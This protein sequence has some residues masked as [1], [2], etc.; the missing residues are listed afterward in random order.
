L[1]EIPRDW[2]LA[3]VVPIYKNGDVQQRENYRPVSLTSTVCKTLERLILD[4]LLKYIDERCPISDNQFGFRS[5]RSCSSQ[6]IS[7]VDMIS[8][9][10]DNN[11]CVDVI[12]LDQSKAFDKVSHSKLI[13]TLI[14]RK[15]PTTLVKWIQHF[16]SNRTLTVK[17]QQLSSPRKVTSGVPQGS[18]L[19][20]ILFLLY[21]EEIDTIIQKPI[22]LFRFADDMK[23]CY[24]FD[25]KNVPQDSIAPLQQCLDRLF[26]W[27]TEYSLPLNLKKCSTVHFGNTNPRLNYCLQ[28]NELDEHTCERD[29]GV[30]IDEHL[31]FQSHID[32]TVKKAR[33]LA[34]LMFH[35]TQY[36]GKEV[37]LPIYKCIIRPVLEY[38]SVVWNPSLIKQIKQ[39]ESVQRYVTKRI[40][41][42]SSLS[43]TQRLSSLGLPRLDTRRAFFDL[44]E[45][46]KVVNG[47]TV[48][49]NRIKLTFLH[50]TTRGH[51]LRIRA[52]KF[53]CNIR[54]SSF[55][56][57]IANT[58]NTLPARIAETRRLSSFKVSLR[59]RL[60][61]CVKWS[62]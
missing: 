13:Q 53:K 40:S 50:H 52:V 56:V 7:Y 14:K 19:G 25:P 37:I 35:S 39:L 1:G 6:L 23:L 45:M 33:R 22:C 48:V 49:S 8:E 36:H 3:Q 34:G 62:S 54:K 55:F 60:F 20:P 41:G 29:L 21:T 46:F 44:V 26:N 58:W 10:L 5:R 17:I 16:L 27:C 28:N 32:A 30:I 11:L 38:A 42:C 12:Y 15:I 31:T 43:Y 47:L 24:A 59:K 18:I 9:A 57:R 61:N 51:S 2:K 4:C